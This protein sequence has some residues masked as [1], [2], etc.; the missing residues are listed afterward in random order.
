MPTIEINGCNYYYESHGNPANETM[1]FS[2]GLLWSGKM[3]RKQVDFFKDRYHIITYDQRGQG[4]SSVPET[5]YELD[6][7]YLDAVGL[8]EKLNLKKV[9]F[10]G[11]SM[12]GFI[13]M[14]LAARR[15][16]LM[17]SLILMETSAELEPST[18]KYALLNTIVKIFGVK[19]IVSPVMKIM[20][21]DKF[22]NDASRKEEKAFWI[23]E[24]LKNKKT[25]TRS[26]RG[27]IRRKGMEEE[28][29][30]ITCP[31]LVMV[32]TQDKATVPAKAEFIH[33]QIPQSKLA[34]VEGAGH[35]SSI[36]EP[37]QVN[38]IIKG[39]LESSPHRNIGT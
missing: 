32:G 38:G 10:I 3:F 18:A 36:E 6:Q 26:V 35:S 19:A 15:P 30:K 24:L 27:I 20:F 2:H 39:F 7:L 9:H 17:H 13:G 1:L 16:D 12:G 5:G 11:L 37:D 8:I 28:I 34:Y 31:V 22:L 14:R 23:S 4:Q 29:T 25:I 33:K 21:G